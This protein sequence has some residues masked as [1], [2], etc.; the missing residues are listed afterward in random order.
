ME[1]L[2]VGS[3]DFINEETLKKYQEL[4]CFIIAAD[5]G[6]DKLYKAGILPELAIGDCDS[7]KKETVD[8]LKKQAIEIRTYPSKKDKTDMELCLDYA[9]EKGY[10]RIVISGGTGYRLD[11]TLANITILVKYFLEGKKVILEDDYNQISVI[12]GANRLEMK[13]YLGQN[14]S[15]IP[16][17]GQVK[18]VA[19]KGLEYSSESLFF[20]F[21]SALGVSN[22]IVDEWVEI[23]IP[24]GIM[25]LILSKDKE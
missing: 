14:L 15:L 11:H 13:A 22:V 4:G 16:M 23:N 7:I 17:L 12:S 20:P 25:L 8:W 2:I 6:A 9:I 19:L 5:G 10:K 21:G 3:G 24:E 1:A 18:D